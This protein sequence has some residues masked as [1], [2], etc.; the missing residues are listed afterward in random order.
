MKCP[1]DGAEL[2]EHGAD[3][4]FKAGAF[5]CNACGCCMY[6]DGSRRDGNAG[7]AAKSFAG[8][9]G[10]VAEVA[11]E[12]SEAIEQLVETVKKPRRAKS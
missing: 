1:H 9:L 11:A 2:I 3:N 12:T 5:H 8:S 10:A 4:P 6:A 7:C